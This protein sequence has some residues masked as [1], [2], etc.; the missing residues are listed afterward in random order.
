MSG[1]EGGRIL[2]RLHAQHG[3]GAWY[4]NPGIVTWAKIKNQMLN[5]LSQQGASRLKFFT[6]H[7][8][9]HYVEKLETAHQILC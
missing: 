7:L 8:L 9:D 4:H 2:S 6:V 5:Q 3:H 1:G